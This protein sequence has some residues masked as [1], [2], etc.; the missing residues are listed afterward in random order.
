[1]ED[2]DYAEKYA[3]GAEKTDI[4]GKIKQASDARFQN[5]TSGFFVSGGAF[6]RPDTDRT[7]GAID[8]GL[9]TYCT[10]Y[11]TARGSLMLMGN[12][13]DVFTGADLG[14]RLQ[15]PTRLAP[16]V[17]GG[18]FGGYARE[19][20]PAA[21]DGIDNDD[22]GFTDE[23]GED[24]ERFSGMLAAIY[25]EVGGHFWWTPNVRLT[26]FGRYMVTTEGRSADD[27]LVGGGIALFTK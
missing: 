17:G 26:G 15:S 3:K 1:M 6:A 16:F 22:D 10:S 4:A 18:F 14:M 2:P 12:D 20:V 21:D 23:R 25:P 11:L 27:W 19:V 5:G 9:E 24:K 13:E 7:L 8:I